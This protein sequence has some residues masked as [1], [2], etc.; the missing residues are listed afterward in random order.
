MTKKIAIIGSGFNALASAFYFTKKKYEVTI[1]FE[2]NI[3]GVLGSVEIENE[4]FDLGFQFFDGLDQKTKNFILEITNNDPC[5]FNFGYGAST[6]SNNKL[7]EYHAIP[8]WPS[9]GYFFTLKTTY[10]TFINFLKNL[11]VK[12]KKEPNTLS[13]VFK[14]FPKNLIYIYEQACLKHYQINSNELD[15]SASEMSTFTNK[16]QTIFNDTISNFLKKN[17]KYFDTNLASRRISNTKLENISLYPKGK[18][19]EYIADKIIKNL[20]NR[21]VKF[22]DTSLDNLN[23]KNNQTGLIINNEFFN[24]AL[25][26][27]S[28]TKIIQILRLKF[29]EKIEHFVS[30]V[31]IYFTVDKI[32]LNF[33]YIQINDL[34]LI[35]S[36]ISNCSLYS[37]KTKDNNK[38]IISEIP[39]TKNNQ[40]WDN[41]KK[42]IELAWTEVQKTNILKNNIGYKSFKI[43]KIKNTFPVPKKDFLKKLNII[44]EGLN[45]SF[46]NKVKLI[47]QGIFTRHTFILELFK[48]FK[49]V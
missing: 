40:L 14:N 45:R 33:Q 24:N 28:L 8:Y 16:R 36:R 43:L 38:V 17:I 11:F 20:K 49:N 39:I 32:D 26:T 13:E 5:L 15:K 23:I 47:G 48:K 3:K 25:F 35:T 6:F 34:N 31:F 10:Y 29:I 1:F 9:Y 42:L 2:K 46:D 44:E 41:D 22:V 37:K 18:N 27:N 4:K 12:N 19:M 30:Q 7:Y 21:K